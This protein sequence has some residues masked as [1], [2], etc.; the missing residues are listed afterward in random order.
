LCVA[1]CKIIGALCDGDGDCCSENCVDAGI[2]G[3]RC[4]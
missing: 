2:L 3:D 1:D 4:G